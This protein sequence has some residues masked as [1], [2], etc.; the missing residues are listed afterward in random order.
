MTFRFETVKTIPSRV[1]TQIQIRKM[2]LKSRQKGASALEY[3]VLAGAIAITIAGAATLFG[4]DIT[5][6]FGGLLDDLTNPS[7]D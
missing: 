7:T 6:F 4:E 1:T 2:T 5:E 3:I